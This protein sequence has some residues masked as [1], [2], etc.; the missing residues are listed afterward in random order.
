MPGHGRDADRRKL[1]TQGVPQIELA[2]RALGRGLRVHGG[3]R[4]GTCRPGS[5]SPCGS[6]LPRT[7]RH[8]P[9]ISRHL[10]RISRHLHARHP[11]HISRHLPRISLDLPRLSPGEGAC[12]EPSARERHVRHRLGHNKRVG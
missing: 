3:N 6:N 1:P 5:G 2:G 8:L 11:P 7:S 4:L 9:R 10:P 12:P